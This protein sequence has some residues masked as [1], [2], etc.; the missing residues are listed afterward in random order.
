VPVFVDTNVLVYARDTADPAKHARASEWVA[1]LWER[2]D[3]R[4]SVQVLQEY[5]VTT[6]RKLRPGLAPEQAR[7]DVLDLAAWSPVVTDIQM[8]ASAWTIEE[9]FGLSFWDALI[10]AAAQVARCDVLLT[11]DMQHGMDL[12]GVRVTDPFRVGPAELG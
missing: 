11:E 12:D 7:A 10:V 2:A 5:Y 4:L 1:D 9:R 8:L 3:G 6:T